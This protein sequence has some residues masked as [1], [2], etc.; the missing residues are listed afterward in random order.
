MSDKFH[1]DLI[2][3]NFFVGKSSSLPGLGFYS[4]FVDKMIT[5]GALFK[6]VWSKRTK[7]YKSSLTYF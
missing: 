7:L 2:F 5:L 1:I 6:A 3:S 4:F